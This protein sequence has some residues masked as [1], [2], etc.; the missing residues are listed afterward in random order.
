MGAQPVYMFFLRRLGITGKL[1]VGYSG[2]NDGGWISWIPWRFWPRCPFAVSMYLDRCFLTD[3]Y[4]RLGNVVRKPLLMA[5]QRVCVVGLKS[6]A[7][8]KARQLGRDS[9]ASMLLHYIPV[10]AFKGSSL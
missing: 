10:L 9:G 8:R 4:A 7:W 5:M 3:A 2:G 1:S 6:D